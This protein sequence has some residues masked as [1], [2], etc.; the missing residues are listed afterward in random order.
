[1]IAKTVRL[2]TT[3]LWLALGL[4][5]VTAVS[6][7]RQDSVVADVALRASR[8]LD[9][10]SGQARG[11]VVILVAG[12]K[13]AKIVPAGSF[14]EKS[15]RSVIDLGNATVLPGLIDAHVHLQIGGQPRENAMAAL[16]AGFTT[17]VDLGATSDVVIRLRDAIAAG[18]SDGPRILAAGR[19]AGTKNG[20]CEFGGIG[21][22][23]GPDGFRQRV[24]EN[25]EAGADLTKVCVSGW[26]A[27]AFAKPDAYEIA[28]DALAAVVEESSRAKRIVVAHAISLG[29]AKAA[30]RAGVRGLA[31]AA[32]L[33]AATAAELRDRDIFVVPTLTTLTSTSRTGCRRP[34]S[35]GRN[36]AS[37]PASASCSGRTA[38][39]CRTA[40]TPPSFAHCAMR[41]SRRSRPF[42]PR[43]RMRLTSSGLAARLA[44]WLRADSPTSSRSM[45]TRSATSRL[46]S[47]W[48]S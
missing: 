23:G 22:A 1:M 6:A 43:R 45:A 33:D 36:G 38:G 3:A 15:A 25:V 18:S 19:W 46:W 47:E 16:R 42:G 7:E 41:D 48:F 4:T 8:L 14:N 44:R 37:A 31:H 21:V 30:S 5:V 28:D 35:G 17:L 40:R 12:Q 24:R 34:Q 39:C 9:P 29:A 26:A 10:A 20:I 13:V 27:A 2:F 32:Y 11:P